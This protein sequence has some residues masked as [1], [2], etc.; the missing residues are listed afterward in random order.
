MAPRLFA[1]SGFSE[2]T[3]F[4][5][6]GDEISIGRVETNDIH[7][8]DRS[9]SRRHCAI[10]N[11]DGVFRIV[12]L[13]SYNGTLV[14]GTSI[15]EQVLRH[16]DQI[17]LGNILFFF[18][19]DEAQHEADLGPIGFEDDLNAGSTIRLLVKNAL[20]LDPKQVLE[21]RSSSER[22]A[23]DLSA[24][25]KFNIRLNKLRDAESLGHHILDSI[26]EA[27][28]VE[29]GVAFFIGESLKDITAFL[30]KNRNPEIQQPIRVS[31]SILDE[32]VREKTA[33]LWQNAQVDGA[34]KNSESLMSSQILSLLCAPLIV[35][36]RVGGVIY[37]DTDDPAHAF[38]ENHLELLTAIAGIASVAL[39]NINHIKS[40]N[41]EN[42]RLRREF[43]LEHD[44]IGE[45]PRMQSVY[46]FIEKAAPTASTI[47]ICG[48]SG[49]GKELV[50]NAIHANSERASSPF[51]AINCAVL[52][53]N[54]LESELFGHEKGSFTGAIARK[55]GKFELAHGGT[56]FLDEIGEM[57]PSL[58]AKLLRVL[59][60]QKFE[61]VGGTESISVDVRIIAATNRDL[62]S[63]IK[64]G[65]FREDLYYRLNVVSL[66]MPPLRE[67]TEDIL[68]LAEYFASKY[69]RKCKRPIAGIARE[70]LACLLAY[71]FPGN[72]REL[73]NAIERAVVLG[74]S[75]TILPED[76]PESILESSS[77]ELPAAK[78]HQAV[79]EMKKNMILSTL[80]QANGNYT[81]AAKLLGI[82]PANLHRVIR[83]MK[84]KHLINKK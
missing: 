66:T 82:H 6:E 40:L 31:Q 46:R 62:E 27:M 63:E 14:N 15:K 16:G 58:Q 35:G 38:D 84:V 30:S 3:S 60:E 53:E 19:F 10:R 4:T 25:L 59:Q 20:Y 83:T 5:L 7:L 76:L 17:T 54:L 22:V 79:N 67:R 44:M 28:P 75:A 39:E 37:L 72:I 56:L 47:L 61:R 42:Q 13:E 18:L 48:E 52:S 68:P 34:F 57:V 81:E 21:S 32:V 80:E 49:T 45:G 50:A 71:D 70:T 26:F 12:D 69:G 78:Y 51:I 2:G 36:E 8:P 9:I 77:S 64:S 41:N 65:R 74:S 1:V 43:N 29:R 23:R 24:L 33:I 73:E 55:K 11:A